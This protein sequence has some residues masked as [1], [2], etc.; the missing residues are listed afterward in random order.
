MSASDPTPL[1]MGF[2][3]A[4]L[5]ARK[6]AGLRQEDL[7]LLANVGRRFVIDLEAGKP[8]CE[9]GRALQVAEVLRI[10]FVA[11]GAARETA[12]EAGKA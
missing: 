8:T 9:I 7:A 1:T 11:A 5:T 12:N 2:G 3:R 6:A 10:R 4:V